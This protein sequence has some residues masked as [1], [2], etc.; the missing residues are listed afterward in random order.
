MFKAH[1]ALEEGLIEITE[2]PA[3][4]TSHNEIKYPEGKGFRRFRNKKDFEDSKA[5]GKL[6]VRKIGG[7][8]VFGAFSP[9]G[10]LY[11]VHEKD[12][13]KGTDAHYEE[14]KDKK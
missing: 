2:E 6:V 1:D 13:L 14:E 8:Y 10:L 11:N 4:D 3:Y 12:G 9:S 5:T 7:K